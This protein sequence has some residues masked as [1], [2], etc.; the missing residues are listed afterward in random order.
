[1]LI[2][3]HGVNLHYEMYGHNG[4]KI[5]LLHGWGCSTKH[6]D[7][8]AHALE[9]QYHLCVIDFPAHGE[10]SRPPEPWGVSDFCDCVEAFMQKIGFFPC[11]II[12]HSFGGRVAL[13]LAS[14]RPD[15][16]ERMVLTGCA[17]LKSQKTPE[18]EKRE[19]KFKRKKNILLTLQKLPFMKNMANQMLR[20]YQQKCGSA[21]YNA[22]DDEMKKTFVKVISE[23]LRPLLPRIQASTLLVW[24]ENDTATPL[25]MGQTME[26]EIPDAGLVVFEN[27]DHY[28][29]LRQWPRFAAIVKAFFV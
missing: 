14:R 29:Y 15:L 22:L 7:Q 24:G 26:K 1:M 6:F 18:Q 20:A 16:I 27:D 13:M 3:V 9:D 12:A 19:A 2:Q 28:A 21:D 10:S 4:P 11:H 17:G 25:W 8:V 23:D 5:L